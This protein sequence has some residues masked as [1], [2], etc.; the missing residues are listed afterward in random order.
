MATSAVPQTVEEMPKR[1]AK[2]SNR[3]PAPVEAQDDR[4]ASLR[5]EMAKHDVQAYIV[6]SEDPHM[7]SLPTADIQWTPCELN[8][9][10][11]RL[12]S[13]TPQLYIADRSWFAVQSEYA[14]SSMERRHFISRFTGSAGTA[15]VT[16]DSAALWTDG[17]YFLQ[18]SALLSYP[19]LKMDPSTAQCR[20]HMHESAT[21]L[22]WIAGRLI[23]LPQPY[24][25]SLHRPA[26]D[27][28]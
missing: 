4:V 9:M 3:A 11:T 13:N 26:N 15:V 21:M 25:P 10:W 16:S 1:A 7:V 12:Q 18:A 22:G 5:R 28:D 8:A 24:V 6:P 27:W 17:R 2:E 20:A 14:P 19:V 23:G